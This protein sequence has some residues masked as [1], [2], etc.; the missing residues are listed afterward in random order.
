VTGNPLWG[1]DVRDYKAGDTATIADGESTVSGYP[2]AALDELPAGD[3]YVQQ[4]TLGENGLLSLD[5]TIDNVIQPPQALA[6]GEVLQLVNYGVINEHR[7][8]QTVATRD[9]SGGQWAIWQA[10]YS[11]VGEDGYPQPLW[12]AT[13][14]ETTTTS[15]NRST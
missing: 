13:T 15:N 8:E 12:D 14:G 4:I 1:V 10:L 7:C 6:G 5:L 2:Y 11:P 9:R 3:Y